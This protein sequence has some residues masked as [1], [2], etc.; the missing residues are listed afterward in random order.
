MDLV[1]PVEPGNE[2][3]EEVVDIV[4]TS[5]DIVEAGYTKNGAWDLKSR[6][7][8]VCIKST[9]CFIKAPLV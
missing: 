7:I 4:K 5:E 2:G 8:F 9:F 6:F 3:K 1:F